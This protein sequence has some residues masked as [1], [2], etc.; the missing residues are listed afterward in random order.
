GVGLKEAK[1][2]VEAMERGESVGI[3]G[4]HIRTSGMSPETVEAAKKIAITSIGGIGAILIIS[5]IMIVGGV[6]AILYFAFSSVQKAEE[7]KRQANQPSVSHPKTNVEGPKDTSELMKIGG[8]GNGA[9]RFKDNRH[10]AV[11][12]QGRIYSSDYSPIKIQVFD[13]SGKFL[14][15]WKPEKGANLYDLTADTSGNLFVANNV[16]VF[17]YAGESGELLA[18][19][20]KIYPKGLAIT[21]DG[22]VLVT[23]GKSLM[24]FDNDLK[25][26]NEVKDAA[27]RASSTSGF[28]AVAVDGE[29]T[30]YVLDRHNGDICKFS[31][32]GKFLNRF[33]TGTTAAHALAVDPQGRIFLSN[34]SDILVFDASGRKVKEFDTYQAFGL[35][36]DQ[37]GDLF[38]ATRPHVT[39]LKLNF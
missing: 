4:M 13:S 36:F 20:E 14:T 8:E 33:P 25:L 35:K 38:I 12:G 24:I 19:V 39:K 6:A 17:K 10:V 31:S 23:A 16:G 22:K 28:E 34:T 15:Q 18:S 26:V 2:A 37:L 29:E 11:D 1:D 32:D 7:S 5:I 9:G 21:W 3:S 27:E 30:M